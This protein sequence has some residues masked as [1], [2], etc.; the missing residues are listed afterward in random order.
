[1]SGA[2]KIIIV[3]CIPAEVILVTLGRDSNVV[4]LKNSR[5]IDAV[6][7]C[8]EWGDYIT[9]CRAWAWCIIRDELYYDDQQDRYFNSDG[10]DDIEISAA[11][12]KTGIPV[13]IDISE[14]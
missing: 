10:D 4:I 5:E 6:K 3:N 14:I 11:D 12:T 13:V 8:V 9:G 1:M 2:K 7:V